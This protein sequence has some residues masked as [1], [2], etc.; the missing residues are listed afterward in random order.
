V[1]SQPATAQTAAAGKYDGTYKGPAETS[2][3]G[4]CMS[5]RP[6]MSVKDGELSLPYGSYYTIKGNVS[7]TGAV[8]GQGVQTFTRGNM[9]ITNL[10]GQITNGVATLVSESPSC[11]FDLKLTKTP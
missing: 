9:K 7:A 5:F 6:T 8:T 4:Y 1:I 3:G 11:H 10:T 2:S